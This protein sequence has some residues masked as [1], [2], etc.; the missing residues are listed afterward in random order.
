MSLDGLVINKIVNALQKLNTGK[1]NHVFQPVSNEI[2]IQ[3]RAHR[4]NSDL[5]INLDANMTRVQITSQK[6]NKPMSPS[7]F[8]MLLRKHLEGGIIRSIEQIDLDRIIKITVDKKDELHDL[9]TK[10]IYIE[11]FTRSANFILCDEDNMIIDVLRKQTFSIDNDRT[12]M[13]RAKYDF[14]QHGHSQINPLTLTNIED[15]MIDDLSGLSFFSKQILHH[16]V[17]LQKDISS[18]LLDTLQDG[19]LFL[20]ESGNKK[21]VSALFPSQLD[22]SKVQTYPIFEALDIYYLADNHRIRI[23]KQSHNLE[24]QVKRLLKKFKKRQANYELDFQNYIDSDHLQKYGDI[25]F[26]HLYM[27]KTQINQKEISL[28]DY[29]TNE[30]ITIPLDQRYG[31]KDNARMYMKR[32]SK[33]KNGMI[34]LSQLIEDTQQDIEYLEDILERFEYSDLEDVVQIEEELLKNRFIQAKQS[35]NTKKK[36]KQKMSV[37][38]YVDQNM[39]R[40]LIGK[41]NLQNSYLTFNYA[42]KQDLWFHTRNV[43]GA[44]VIVLNGQLDEMTI[45]TA[46]NLAALYSASK[47]SSSVEIAYC[48]VNQLKKGKYSGQALLTK[49]TTIFIDPDESLLTTKLNKVL[50]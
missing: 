35:S 48:R 24:K 14:N 43:S 11:L 44:H 20:Y 23:K 5:M 47:L 33:A 46:A 19:N 34:Y 13:P 22:I 45:R 28:L 6:Y 12:L 7:S 16:D 32:Y 39:T 21:D 8:T 4:E 42:H 27:I 17:T 38:E 31:V 41:N 1:I 9:K 37:L 3:V 40:Y 50:I 36:K 18:V 10:I 2:I 15:T 26:T 29:E 49:Y 30:M 25:L